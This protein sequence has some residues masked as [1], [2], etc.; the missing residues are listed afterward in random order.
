MSNGQIHP[1][2]WIPLLVEPECEERAK[3][4]RAERDRRYRNIYLEAPTDERW[5][6]EL[7]EMVF[8]S[9]LEHEGIQ[10]FEWVLDNAAGRPDF[11]TA[12]N[13]R[14]GV[15]DGPSAKCLP[16]STTPPRSPPAMQGNLPTI[17]SS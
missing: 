8:N 9:W 12:T 1:Q 3:Q 17:S 6:G 16:A 7:G 13:I 15:K 10:G 5:V 2:G 4:M 11:V 14:I